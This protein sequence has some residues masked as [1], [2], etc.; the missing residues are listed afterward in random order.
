MSSDDIRDRVMRI[1]VRC[2]PQARDEDHPIRMV[3]DEGGMFLGQLK[4]TP[5]R[6]SDSADSLCRLFRSFG[7]LSEE[8]ADQLAVNLKSAATKVWAARN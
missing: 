4:F 1:T 5:R 7:F 3:F 6:A 2:V 8:S